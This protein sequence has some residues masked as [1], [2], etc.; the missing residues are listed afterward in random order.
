MN[1]NFADQ[2]FEESSW[3]VSEALMLE[4]LNHLN[5]ITMVVEMLDD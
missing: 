3:A 1:L 2:D 5:L 4:K